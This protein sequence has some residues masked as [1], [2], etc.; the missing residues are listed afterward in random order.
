MISK[1]DIQV[2]GTNEL[3]KAPGPKLSGGLSCLVCVQGYSVGRG[4]N[5]MHTTLG[6]KHKTPYSLVIL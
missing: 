1:S 5:F 4:C 2:T 6:P 3:T